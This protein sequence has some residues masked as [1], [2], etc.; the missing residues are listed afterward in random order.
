[1]AEMVPPFYTTGGGNGRF[2]RHPPLAAAIRARRSSSVR[3]GSVG[4]VRDHVYLTVNVS[5]S[6]GVSLPPFGPTRTFIEPVSH[7]HAVPSKYF[8]S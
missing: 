1:M 7:C 8:R 3:L 5:L 2:A 4:S 6:M